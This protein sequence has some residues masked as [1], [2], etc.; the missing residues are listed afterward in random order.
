MDGPLDKFA[1]YIG[2]L[3]ALGV[4]LLATPLARR[5]AAW[6]GLVDRPDGQRKLQRQPVALLGGLAVLFAVIGGALAAAWSEQLAVSLPIGPLAASLVGVCLLGVYDDVCNLRARWKFVGQLVAV[7][8]LVCS[9]L[10]LDRIS[11]AGNVVDLGWWGPV[12]TVLWLVACINAINLIDGLDG[13]ASTTGLCAALAGASL[14]ATTGSP[15]A[16]VLALVLAGALAGFLVY[17]LPPAKIY[18]G[19]AG[20]MLVGLASG[21]LALVASRDAAGREHV[22]LMIVLLAVPIGDVVLAI[23]RR[24]LGGNGF[25]MPDRG[26]IHHRLLERGFSTLLVLGIVAVLCLVSGAVAVWSRVVGW[27]N[28]AW[29][30]CVVIAAALIKWRLVGHHEWSLTKGALAERWQLLGAGVPLGERLAALPFE[31]LWRRLERWAVWWR[32]SGM[33]VSTGGERIASRQRVWTT[34]SQPPDPA[35][36]PIV[37]ELRFDTAHETWC[38]VRLEANAADAARLR[39]RRLVGTIQLLGQFWAEHPLA[40]EAGAP[41]ASSEEPSP[42]TIQIWPAASGESVAQQR[43]A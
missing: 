6:S 14:A 22:T 4:S 38:H 9:G 34:E 3:T 15:E 13:L 35:R 8:P 32:L 24:G 40:I 31:L 10:A 17:N 25:W 33:Q 21:V 42:S 37:V 5:I 16:V 43:A 41:K 27:D 19:D 1:T 2:C 12:L 29:L 11:F 36:P 7:L 20:S 39:W 23:V 28:L 18:L 30:A 26:H